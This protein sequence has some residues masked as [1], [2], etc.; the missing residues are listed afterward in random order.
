VNGLEDGWGNRKLLREAEALIGRKIDF[1]VRSDARTAKAAIERGLLAQEV[2]RRSRL[3]K[4]IRK[5]LQESA[6]FLRKDAPSDA[7]PH[8]AVPAI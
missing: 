1:C 5:L 2:R 6:R 8:N 4:D 7:L 3:E